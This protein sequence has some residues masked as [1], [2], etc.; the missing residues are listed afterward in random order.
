MRVHWPPRLQ[1]HPQAGLG[2]QV[3]Q[4]GVLRDPRR[5]R[6]RPR[7]WAGCRRSNATSRRSRWSQTRRCRSRRRDGHRRRRRRCRLPRATARRRR[8]RSTSARPVIFAVTLVHVFPASR[9]TLTTPSSVPVQITPALAADSSSVTMLPNVPTPSFLATRISLPHHAHDRQRFA[10]G[11]GRQVGADRR[12]RPAAVGRLHHQL[13]ADVD[14]G[15]VVRR[16]LH[17]RVPVVAE[18]RGS[19][20]FASAGSGRTVVRSLVVRSTRLMRPSCDS[21]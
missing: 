4:V 2:A 18:R 11:V 14:R 19:P 21:A 12:V 13:R 16:Q 7:P 15:R 5:G 20:A 9:V 3:E 10:I 8:R 17:R 1:R 6:G